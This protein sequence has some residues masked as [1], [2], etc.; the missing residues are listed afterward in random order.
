MCHSS[1]Y[2]GFPE[3]VARVKSFEID[4]LDFWAVRSILFVVC[5]TEMGNGVEGTVNE[6][7][8]GRSIL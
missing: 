8:V 4:A 2:L 5:G 6:F 1:I 7:Y 3:R